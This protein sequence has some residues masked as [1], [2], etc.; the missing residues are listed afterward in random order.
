MFT[1]TLK[2]TDGKFI[3]LQVPE[4]AKELKLSQKLDIDF[5]QF[6]IISYLKKHEDKL[7]ESRAGYLLLIAKGISQ[8]FDVDLSEIMNLEGQSILEINEEDIAELLESISGKTKKVLKTKTLEKSL[9][10]IWDFITIVAN[11]PDQDLP[12]KIQ[13]KGINYNLPKVEKHPQ[14]GRL[15][16]K[17]TTV[18][19]AIETIQLENNY[20]TWLSKNPSLKDSETN[21]SWLFTKY[22]SEVSLLL[23]PEGSDENYIPIDEDEYE[24]FMANKTEHFEDIDWQTVFWIDLWFNNYIAELKLDKENEYFFNSTFEPSSKE[25]L[26]AMQTAQRKGKKI[27]ENVGIKS[28]IPTLMEIDPYSENGKSKFWSVMRSKFSNA[29]KIIST[30]NARG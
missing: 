8:V 22:L 11:N 28:I 20:H 16:H 23:I 5:V 6:E 4:N 7:F 10:Q 1:I 30:H 25:E 14:S 18:K 21:K 13:Y 3:N 15:L 2:R 17:S 12:E 27:N 29:V 19:Q 26:E 9:L 24:L